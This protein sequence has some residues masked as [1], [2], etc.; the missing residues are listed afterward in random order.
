MDG[1]HK[2]RT[3]TGLEDLELLDV[4]AHDLL[5][6]PGK[7]GSILSKD[8]G[9]TLYLSPSSH[10]RILLYID[11]SPKDSSPSVIVR[12]MEED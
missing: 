5:K 11:I 3:T 9:S 1:C 8:P 12:G 4:W 10:R 2:S 6:L 7:F